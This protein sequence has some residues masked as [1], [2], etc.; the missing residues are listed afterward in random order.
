MLYVYSGNIKEGKLRAYTDWVRENS[1]AL[2]KEA[3]NG[4]VLKGVFLTVLGF[5]E[6]LT[7]IHWEVE[8]YAAFDAAREASGREGCYADLIRAWFAFLDI[9]GHH[10][11]LLRRIDSSGQDAEPVLL[12]D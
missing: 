3:P 8:N 5:G 7:E 6:H 1:G 9:S 2:A 12:V 10:G 11:R 4:H